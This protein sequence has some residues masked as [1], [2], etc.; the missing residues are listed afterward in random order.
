MKN[1][2]HIIKNSLLSF[3][4]CLVGGS[5]MFAADVNGWGDFKL[6]LDPGHAQRENGG[7]YNYSE[8]E[9]VLRVAWSIR[10]YLLKY[11]DIPA[12][13]IKLCRETDNDYIDLT[14][15]VD[16]ANAWDADFY[17]SI[18]S[19]AGDAT[20]P[21]T[22]LTMFGG[23]RNNG[24]EIEKTPN[25]GKAFGEFLCPNLSGVMQVDTRGNWYDRCYYDKSPATH[26][27]QYPYLAVNRRSNMPSLLSEGGYHTHA[28]Q[29]QRNINE[30]YKRLEGYAAF[31]SILQYRGFDIPEQ[32]ILAGV[33]SNSENGV[34]ANGVTITVGDQSV[35]TDS[36]ESIFNK[37]SR[38]PNMLHNGFFMFEDLE[39][40]KEYTVTFSSP[41]YGTTEKKV[42][43][44][45][46]P[47][48]TAAEN[49]TW[50][51]VQLTSVAP[52]KVDQISA[53]D[54]SAVSKRNPLTITFSRNMD[55]ESVKQAFSISNN[56]EVS[57]SWENGYTL[58]VDISKLENEQTYKIT[59]DG[60]IAKNEQTG[61][62]FDG[63]G[64][65]EEGGNYE[66]EFTIEPFD[67]TAPEI[68]SVDPAIDG[69]SLCTYRPVIRVE[70]S[71]EIV[72][73]EDNTNDLIT[74]T[75]S[76]NNAYAGKLTHDVINGTSV[77]HYFLNED[78]PLDKCFLV[79]VKGGLADFS[80]N[81][82]EPFAWKFLSEYRN[83]T[84]T[85]VVDKLD[86]TSGWWAPSGSGSTEGLIVDDSSWNTSSETYSAESSASC[87][88]IYAFDQMATSS[89]WQ[90]REYRQSGA[91]TVVSNTTDGVLQFW[92]YGDGSNNQVSAMVRA[93]SA[94]GGLK[95]RTMH[96]ISFKGW[97]LLTWDMANE[98][99][100]TFTGTDQ[101]NGKWILDSFFM[102]HFDKS[103]SPEEPQQAWNGRILFDDLTFVTYDKTANRTASLDDI[104]EGSSVENITS[105]ITV[106][107]QGKTLTIAGENIQ[108]IRI[109][110]LSGEMIANPGS[111]Q[112]MNVIDMSQYANGMYLLEIQT[113]SEHMVKKIAF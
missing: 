25:G 108:S 56:G 48:G 57:L 99:Y 95:H 73:N 40:G 85:I 82:S 41:E 88:L 42:T 104:S 5:S 87:E 86:S 32:T 93:N 91:S 80:G 97:K 29:Q 100:E 10:D 58:N 45:S 49:I 76:E 92:L 94:S 90:I 3:S 13:N 28:F 26:T 43:I 77:I 79:K 98:P 62:F 21:N 74:L 78:L 113:Q 44:I 109:F 14:D 68:V 102:K 46:N 64:D 36:Y 81:L 65:G 50:F 111:L 11:T 34:A 52:A 103:S 72:W 70:F 31:R 83:A 84:N 55:Q 27:N 35:T 38:D 112:F 30:S 51:D 15:R 101:L 4:L 75:D 22:T 105:G 110:N 69:E 20:T 33:V 96:P 18:H 66:L 8:S 19:D 71:E 24:V 61:Q 59:I 54:L 67:E 63:D 16:V 17:Y 106:K 23:W 6:Y 12:E 9:K 7:L 47:D 60:A 39:A 1:F 53:S 37:Y 89:V 107:Q 2:T